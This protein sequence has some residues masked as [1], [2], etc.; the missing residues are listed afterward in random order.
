MLPFLPL[1]FFELVLLLLQL[2]LLLL[3]LPVLQLLLQLLL[4]EHFEMLRLHDLKVS[5]TLLHVF[6]GFLDI[7][8]HDLLLCYHLSN[9]IFNFRVAWRGR[10]VLQLLASAVVPDRRMLASAGSMPLAP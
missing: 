1:G 9:F 3:L 4:L 6:S 7:A 2:L 8:L 5:H 10:R